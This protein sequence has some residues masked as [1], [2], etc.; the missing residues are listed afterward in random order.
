ML[1]SARPV[2]RAGTRRAQ[3]RARPARVAAVPIGSEARGSNHQQLPTFT[4][5]GEIG[6]T[7][8]VVVVAWG[9]LDP[10]RMGLDVDQIGTRTE[11][12]RGID[13]AGRLPGTPVAGGATVDIG[14]TAVGRLV[15]L[16]H[17]LGTPAV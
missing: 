12:R 13:D 17:D 8:A 14:H 9:L 10:Q 1:G 4:L 16:G 11:G 3:D 15:H 5:V 7:V 6:L 2:D